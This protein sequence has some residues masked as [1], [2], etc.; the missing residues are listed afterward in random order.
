LEE[1]AND[2]LG[3]FSRLEGLTDLAAMVVLLLA[4]MEDKKHDEQAHY[5]TRPICPL[6]VCDM[7]EV[8]SQM[9]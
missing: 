6:R 8:E 3:A 7:I 2:G 9:S 5:N 1:G 4:V